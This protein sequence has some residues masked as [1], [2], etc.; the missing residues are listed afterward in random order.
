MSS[1]PLLL[2]DLI[3]PTH[4]H[5][6]VWLL[7]LRGHLIEMYLSS[8]L[9]AAWGFVSRDKSAELTFTH[10]SALSFTCL[11]ACFFL[12]FYF[13]FVLSLPAISKYDS[14]F[15]MWQLEVLLETFS[16]AL[17]FKRRIRLNWF[18][19]TNWGFWLERRQRNS[20]KGET[21]KGFT[22]PVESSQLSSSRKQPDNRDSVFVDI[23]RTE[24]CFCD[25]R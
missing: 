12:F 14:V 4:C 11:P 9:C 7:L 2:W 5:L 22:Q 15:C 6:Y 8:H 24:M 20:W 1:L 17:D 3:Y 23:T 25:P 10:S 18:F 19:H 13:C 21:L 16:P